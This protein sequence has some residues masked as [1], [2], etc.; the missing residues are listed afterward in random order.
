MDEKK[1][2]QIQNLE[3]GQ[4]EGVSGG[5]CARVPEPDADDEARIAADEEL[6]QGIPPLP[7]IW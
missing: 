2:E 5:A 4:L 3:D 7:P 6:D 1:L